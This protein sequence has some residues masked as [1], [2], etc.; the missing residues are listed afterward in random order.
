MTL[1][2]YVSIATSL[3]LSFSLARTLT[4][5]HPSSRPST[6]IGSRAHG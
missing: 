5:S 3:I 6:A 4:I 2:E 1:Y